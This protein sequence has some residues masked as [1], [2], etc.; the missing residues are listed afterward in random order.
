MPDL[1]NGT[2]VLFESSFSFSRVW[3]LAARGCAQ[4][5]GGNKSEQIY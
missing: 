1:K 5:Q 4:Q 3:R 2:P